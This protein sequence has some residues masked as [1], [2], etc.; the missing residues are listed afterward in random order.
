MRTQ[1]NR[2]GTLTGAW[3]KYWGIHKR[4]HNPPNRNTF[5]QHLE[6]LRMIELDSAYIPP[7]GYEESPKLYKR[8]LYTT[9]DTLIRNNQPRGGMR[10]QK[11]WKDLDWQQ[12]WNNLHM[13]PVS[14]ITKGEWYRIIHDISTNERLQKIRLSPTDKCGICQ[15]T[16][17]LTHRMTECGGGKIW[18]WTRNRLAMILRI[19]QRYIPNDWMR[20]HFGLW[21]P[22]R[23]RAVLWILAHHAT[24]SS[25]Q[26]RKVMT[27]EDFLDILRR[28]KWKI[29]QEPKR[30][31]LVGNYLSI[32]EPPTK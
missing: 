11:A 24:Y 7:I 21:P 18:R 15:N 20:P 26:H 27:M 10:I 4:S 32:L 29:Y 5:P 30:M 19:D 31:D 22:K 13:A 9:I 14:E 8:R 1:E 28:Q 25:Q 6:Y 23:H 2:E 12:I 16:D 17:T 3:L